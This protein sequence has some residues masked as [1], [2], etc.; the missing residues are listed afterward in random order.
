MGVKDLWW[1]TNS[2]HPCGPSTNYIHETH[3]HWRQSHIIMAHGGGLTF[4]GEQEKNVFVQLW[5][6]HNYIVPEVEDANHMLLWS[7]ICHVYVLCTSH[8]WPHLDVALCP[9]PLIVMFL[10]RSCFASSGIH[11]PSITC[12]LTLT[13]YLLNKAA[14]L[15]ANFLKHIHNLA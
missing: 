7:C 15:L 11:I 9:R 12:L 13:P 6:W 4:Q 5:I 10:Q 1:C 2:H 8:V 3:K 14:C